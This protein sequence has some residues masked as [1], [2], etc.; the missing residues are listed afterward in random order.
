[1][2]DLYEHARDQFFDA[3]RAMAISSFDIQSRLADAYTSIRE[4]TLDEFDDDPELKLKLARILDLLAV[5]TRDVDDEVVE[6]THRMSDIE[7]AKVAHLICDFY[8][9]LG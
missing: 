2:D 3:L 6:T 9:E 4:V 5:D 1:M 8:Y 7:A